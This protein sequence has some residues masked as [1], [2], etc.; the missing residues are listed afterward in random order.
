M[1]LQQWLERIE[2]CHPETIE[3][4]LER[5]RTVLDALVSA[6]LDPSRPATRVITVAGTNG[7]GS[8]VALLDSILRQAGFSTGC[9][10]S[11]HLLRYN[12]RVVINGEAVSDQQL[13]DSF[14]RIEQ[15]RGDTPL[16]YFEYGTLSALLIF[17]EQQM[18]AGQP[19]DVVI[20]EVGLG[21]RLDAV[22]VIDPDVAVLTTIALD[23]QAWLGD[24][25]DVIGR[26]K[27]GIF[28]AGTPA[29]CGD[30]ALPATVVDYAADIG[31]PL[32]RQGIEFQATVKDSG[33]SWHG[34]VA[35][36]SRI[37]ADL[38]MPHLPLPNAA[39]AIQTVLTLFPELD[40]AAIARGLE[41]ASVAGRYQRVEQPLPMILDVAH[42]PESAAYLAQRLAVEENAEENKTGQCYGVVG[43]LQDK[44]AEAVLAHLQP[45]VDHWLVCELSVARAC[46]PSQLKN[47]LGE[48]GNGQ[49]E[50]YGSVAQTLA[51]L[52]ERLTTDDRVLVFGSFFTVADALLWLEQCKSMSELKG[53]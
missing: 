31:A 18:V 21:G 36:E 17:A 11:P 33:W 23:H 44:D 3:L 41:N 26:E 40:P 45:H 25:R 29:V 20:L 16:T 15:A 19:L 14:V 1:N 51:A 49:V 39:T 42:N 35:G 10:T 7:K 37:L 38:P 22:N 52:Q 34:Q 4:G 5:V 43:M 24:S 30:P 6:E 27:A 9:Y 50:C 46:P 48:L 2:S 53:G 12:E 32:S 8:T 47:T 13:C 28:R